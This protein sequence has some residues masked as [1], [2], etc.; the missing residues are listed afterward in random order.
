MAFYLVPDEAARVA[1]RDAAMT[2]ARAVAGGDVRGAWMMLRELADPARGG[3]LLD[4]AEWLAMLA[5][6]LAAGMIAAGAPED[7]LW[8]DV[9]ESFTGMPEAMRGES[10]GD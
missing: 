7:R 9:A 2:L 5:G 3:E 4:L 10:F 1:N 6:G 8:A